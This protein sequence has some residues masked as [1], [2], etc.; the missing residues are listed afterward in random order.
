MNVEAADFPADL[1]RW[2][3][4]PGSGAAQAELVDIGEVLCD[5]LAEGPV[6]DT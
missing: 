1:A 5:D 4:D 3:G 2:E 6:A